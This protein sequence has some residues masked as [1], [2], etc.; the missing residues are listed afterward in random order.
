MSADDELTQVHIDL[1]NHWA[2]GGEAMWA[3]ALGGNRYRIENVPFYAYGLNFYD[4]VEGSRQT[5]SRPCSVLP[6]EAGT[7]QSGSCSTPRCPRL[8]CWS[9]LPPC[10]RSL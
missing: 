6:K 2:V 8:R 10:A 9:Y 4:V 1:P 3:R 5:R 7:A